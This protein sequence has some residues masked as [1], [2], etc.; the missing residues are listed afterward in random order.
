MQMKTAR[1]YTNTSDDTTCLNTEIQLSENEIQENYIVCA[2][3]GDDCRSGRIDN[4]TIAQTPLNKHIIQEIYR[5]VAQ[6]LAIQCKI[7]CKTKVS[8]K[9]L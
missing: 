8:G 5:G 4:G 6:A 9:T 3:T 1:A 2:A 7:I